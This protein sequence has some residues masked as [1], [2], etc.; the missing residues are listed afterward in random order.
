[1][2]V[3]EQGCFL[4][5]MCLVYY[6]QS[7]SSKTLQIHW[8]MMTLCYLCPS[9]PDTIFQ[10][11]SNCPDFGRL[12][13]Y[14]LH[15]PYFLSS[16]GLTVFPDENTINTAL[17][18]SFLTGPQSWC[19]SLQRSTLWNFGVIWAIPPPK[20]YYSLPGFSLLLYWLSFF[21]GGVLSFP[22]ASVAI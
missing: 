1:M 14:Y 21:S 19:L 8:L 13:V 9:L 22:L 17:H 5:A 2:K 10:P 4:I 15:F 12:P 3:S 20:C 16:A 6:T 7:L 11:P 18:A